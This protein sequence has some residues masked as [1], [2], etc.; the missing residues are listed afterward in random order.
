MSRGA[1]IDAHPMYL[2]IVSG[3]HYAVVPYTPSK[4]TLTTVEEATMILGSSRNVVQKS[5]ANI[6][7]AAGS[8]MR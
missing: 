7:V 3:L 6:L 2:I 1:T 8:E 4:A 5:M